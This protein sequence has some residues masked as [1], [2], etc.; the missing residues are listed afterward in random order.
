MEIRNK[1]IW[2]SYYEVSVTIDMDETYM[3][4]VLDLRTLNY[5]ELVKE[6]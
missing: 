4:N 6:G 1:M 2:L 5:S 3:V